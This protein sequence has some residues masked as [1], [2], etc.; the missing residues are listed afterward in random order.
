MEDAVARLLR[1]IFFL[2]HVGAEV[3]H[4]ASVKSV[5]A[6]VVRLEAEIDGAF[7]VALRLQPGMQPEREPADRTAAVARGKFEIQPVAQRLEV[8]RERHRGAGDERAVGVIPCGSRLAAGVPA[9]EAHRPGRALVGIGRRALGKMKPLD[10]AAIDLEVA[11]ALDGEAE[12]PVL[13][14]SEIAREPVAADELHRGVRL[15]RHRRLA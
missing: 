4:V 1:R 8:P 11:R 9:C 7:R 6:D 5:C 10:L 3:L 2:R 15:L 12:F 13:Q 14:R